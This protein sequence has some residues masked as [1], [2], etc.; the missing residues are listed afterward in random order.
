[1]TEIKETTAQVQ[2]QSFEES[3]ARLEEIVRAMEAG[4][5]PL[6]QAIAEFQEG[7]SLARV[8]REKLDQAE[9][10]IQMLVQES[11]QLVKKPFTTTEE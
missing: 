7:M 4:D 3:L 5:L 6:E 10:K 8:C 1:M 9:Q 2:E 11:G